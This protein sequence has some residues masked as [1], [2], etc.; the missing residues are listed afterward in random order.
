METV[1][2][3]FALRRKERCPQCPVERVWTN[4]KPTMVSNDDDEYKIISL[5]EELNLNKHKIFSIKIFSV[6]Q[7]LLGLFITGVNIFLL[8]LMVLWGIR[9]A[10]STILNRRETSEVVMSFSS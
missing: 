4:Y 6:K 2:L 1:Q 7:I 5:S 10:Y 8:G 9:L 3:S